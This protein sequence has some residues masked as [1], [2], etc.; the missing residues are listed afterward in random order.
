MKALWKSLRG[1]PAAIAFIVVVM[2]YT[3]LKIEGVEDVGALVVL[4]SFLVVRIAGKRSAAL[5][6]A[7]RR[8]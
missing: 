8:P 6:S 4:A 1:E 7:W 3:H 2:A 5:P